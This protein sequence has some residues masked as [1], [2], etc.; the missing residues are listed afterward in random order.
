MS[1]IGLAES[2]GNPT[3]GRTRRAGQGQRLPEQSI[4]IWQINLLAHPEYAN[5][6]LTNPIT[7][8]RAAL[9]IFNHEGLRAWGSYIDGRYR[10]YFAGDSSSVP[11]TSAPNV[12]QPINAGFNFKDFLGVEVIGQKNRYLIAFAILVLIFVFAFK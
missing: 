9:D 5:V 6:D 2:D 7:N 10:Q 3:A 4:G 1:A 12:G 8:A 11:N